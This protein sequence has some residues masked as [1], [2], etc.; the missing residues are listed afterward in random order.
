MKLFFAVLMVLSFQSQTVLASS[1]NLDLVV[2]QNLSSAL[3]EIS[4]NVRNDN[5]TFVGCVE[6]KHHCDAHAQNTG[7]HHNESNWSS[8]C[9]SLDHHQSYACYGKN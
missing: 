5:W 1:S 7:Y 2:P 8:N 9:N 4:E 6:A 3:G